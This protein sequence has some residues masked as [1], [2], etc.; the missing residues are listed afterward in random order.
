M[1]WCASSPSSPRAISTTLSP[2]A[3]IHRNREPLGSDQG[4][5]LIPQARDLRRVPCFVLVL[6]LVASA[7]SVASCGGGGASDSA[8]ALQ[9]PP[10]LQ[11][12]QAPSLPIYVPGTAFKATDSSGN[13]WTA[14]YSSTA[15]GTSTFNG[16]LAYVTAISFTVQ[17]NATV[18]DSES[19]S[20]FALMNPYSPLGLTEV[21]SGLPGRI[22]TGS[23]TSYDPLPSTLTTGES[24]TLS[25]GTFGSC[26]C[27]FTE[28]YSVTQDS[29]TALFLNIHSDF[30]D[31]GLFHGEASL[32]GLYSGTST[33]TYSITGSG[34]AT[35]VKIQVTING[36]TLTF[37]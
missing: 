17:K 23:I 21:F 36:T 31:F 14:T 34:T 25:S 5:R 1:A 33:I 32:T 16:Q 27:T 30:P 2:C 7:C 22:S 11:S 15:A 3:V 6:L 4:G 8:A 20:E 18:I 29:P 24:G 13:T 9:N 10:N 12:A 35:L 26:S 37:Q 19:Y 28:T